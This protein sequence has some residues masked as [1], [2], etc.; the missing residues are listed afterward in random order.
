MSSD[1]ID[2]L[3][4]QLRDYKTVQE[5][6]LP[7]VDGDIVQFWARLGKVLMPGDAFQPRFPKLRE[8]TTILLVLPYANA[9]PERLFS[10]VG[11]TGTQQR[12]S[13]LP[14]TVRDFISVK[15]NYL[16]HVNCHT[17]TFPPSGSRQGSQDGHHEEAC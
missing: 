5:V 8:L 4:T 16:S 1:N 17:V 6:Q 9:D 2:L 15:V 14:S 3:V 7:A 10:M 11:K 12:V 13:L